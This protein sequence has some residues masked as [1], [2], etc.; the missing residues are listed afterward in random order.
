MLPANPQKVGYVVKRYPRYSE[1]FIVNEIL[2]HEEAGLDLEIFALR[3]PSD[4][5]FQPNI[6][7][8]KAPVTYL[9]E[10]GKMADFWGAL[11][12][13]T[14][15]MP[16]SLHALAL[17]GKVDGRTVLQAMRLALAVKER[18]IT[19][20]H[21]HFA[22]SAAS[23]ARIAARLAH[24]PYSITAHAKD[25]FHESVDEQDV[26]RKIRDASTVVTVSNYNLN[27][28]RETY[29]DAA[30]QVTRIYNGLDLEAFPFT[31][32]VD[33][34]RRIVAVGRLVEKKGFGDLVDACAL[35]ARQSIAFDCQIVGSG[36]QEADL[37][38]RIERQHLGE[39]VTLMGPRPQSEII[40]LL[41]DAS[42]FAAP[43]VIG[44]DGNRDGL[45]TVLL[46]SMAL[47]TP[48]ISTDVTGIPEIL[49]DNDTGL[50]TPQHNP[51]ALAEA[52]KRL[53]DDSNLRVRLAQNARR[54]IESQ[55]DIHRNATMLRALFTPWPVTSGD[56][57]PDRHVQIEEQI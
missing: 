28:L 1:T 33:R 2:A 50:M 52:I 7:K 57:L 44:Q 5:H 35:L 27:F 20:L 39:H 49:M 11:I 42:V 4:T 47:G 37:R 16:G 18:G 51:A 25:I 41:R 56:A 46:E 45:P 38:D 14:D 9:P 22:T 19:H 6:A 10:Q 24:I 31:P 55:F 3:P 17:F 40:N 54:L 36:D 32:P 23:V 15:R 8:V 34:P 53:L 26:R 12:E 13:V 43:C 30:A 21:A 29:D 48:C